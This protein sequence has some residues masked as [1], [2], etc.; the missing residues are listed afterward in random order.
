MTYFG[1]LDGSGNIWVFAFLISW[2]HTSA[3]LRPRKLSKALSKQRAWLST[4]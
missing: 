1:I 3:A 4:T 2:A